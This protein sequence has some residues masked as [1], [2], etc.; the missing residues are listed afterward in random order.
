M[1][2]ADERA[3]EGGGGGGERWAVVVF[4]CSLGIFPAIKCQTS[5]PPVLLFNTDTESSVERM[6]QFQISQLKYI[7][8]ILITSAKHFVVFFSRTGYAFISGCILSALC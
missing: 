7:F 2:H 1:T 3:E 5:L 4:V 6:R 8:E